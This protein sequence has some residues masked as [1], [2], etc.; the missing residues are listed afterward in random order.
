VRGISL[1]LFP[2]DRLAVIGRNGAGKSTLL[3]VMA[4][5]IAPDEGVVCCG[6]VSRQQL[7]LNPGFD[8]VLTGEENAIL[9]GMYLGRT[10]QQMERALAR[11]ETLSELG[12][13]FTQ[14]ISSYSSGMKARL[15]LAVA[16]EARP[17][18]LLLDEF[19]GTTGDAAFQLK[20]RSLLDEKMQ[21]SIKAMVIVSHSPESIKEYC[22]RAVLI[23]NGQL[24]AE[25][26]VDGILAQYG[27]VITKPGR[28]TRLAVEVPF[29]K[30]LGK[31]R[32]LLAG[33]TRP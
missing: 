27:D 31:W 9:S 8:P 23:E 16:M 18:I 11:I 20:A 25:G 33:L 10:H 19:L 22:N 26:G 21:R 14:P 2:G 29:R 4:G 3:S 17:D 12:V 32:R 13:F 30:P 28:N 1:K 5:I 24:V 6:T 7:S 15:G